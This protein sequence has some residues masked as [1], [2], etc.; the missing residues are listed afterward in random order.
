MS[1]L[2]SHER[3]AL[4]LGIDPTHYPRTW[5]TSY[6]YETTCDLETRIR[7]Q[8]W[9]TCTALMGFFASMKGAVAYKAMLDGKR[10]KAVRK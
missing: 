5:R 10:G 6:G 8:R 1:A 2:A 7:N 4:A 3:T 9:N